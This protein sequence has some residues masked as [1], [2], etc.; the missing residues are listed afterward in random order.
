[1]LVKET[2][3]DF[4][5]CPDGTHLA[6]CCAVIALGTQPQTNPSFKE[7]FKT[8]LVWE[9]PNELMENGEPFTVSK[10]YTASLSEKA[11]LRHHLQGWRGKPFSGQELK[12]FALENVLNVPC[13]VTVAHEQNRAQKVYAK[14]VGVAAPLKGTSVPELKRKVVHYELDHGEN[15]VYKALPEWVR[16]KIA[17]CRERNHPEPEPVEAGKEPE[18]EAGNSDL[19]F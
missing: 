1:M 13:M 9:L 3:S 14:V 6:R 16:K 11:T 4:K 10:E 15:D 8:L 2:G 17:Q 5:P 18:D 12:G 7:T 19:P